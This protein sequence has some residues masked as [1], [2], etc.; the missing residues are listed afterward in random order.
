MEEV[1][2]VTIEIYDDRPEIK[3]RSTF[4][5]QRPADIGI[6]WRQRY[7]EFLRQYPTEK[8]AAKH[9][10]VSNARAMKERNQDSEFEMACQDAIDHSGERIVKMIYD[11]AEQGSDQLLMFIARAKCGFNDARQVNVKGNVQHDHDHGGDVNVNVKDLRTPEE[12][13]ELLLTS[14]DRAI[15]LA[16]AEEAKQEVVEMVKGENGGY[17]PVSGTP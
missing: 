5:K 6:D 11:R 17:E 13:K 2:D 8:L 15:D 1:V 10:G 7:I 16:K 4:P 3:A 9:A 14:I 12:R